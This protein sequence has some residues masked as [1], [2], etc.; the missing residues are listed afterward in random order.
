MAKPKPIYVLGLDMTGHWH[1]SMVETEKALAAIRY[2][3][4]RTVMAGVAATMHKDLAERINGKHHK[5]VKQWVSKCAKRDKGVPLTEVRATVTTI[6][7]FGLGDNQKTLKFV[8]ARAA[9]LQS[10]GGYRPGLPFNYFKGPSGILYHTGLTSVQHKH[11]R[12]ARA[13]RVRA[14][15]KENALV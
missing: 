6:H 5:I 3:D 1:L 15:L 4:L 9:S 13:L 7:E 2:A 10:G 8:E 12:S 11:L 14:H